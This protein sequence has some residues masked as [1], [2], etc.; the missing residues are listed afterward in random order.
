MTGTLGPHSETWRTV[1]SDSSVLIFASTPRKDG[2]GSVGRVPKCGRRVWQRRRGFLGDEAGSEHGE[3]TAWLLRSAA[4]REVAGRRA[5]RA[6]H[7]EHGQ[8]RPTAAA[9]LVPRQGWA[10]PRAAIQCSGPRRRGGLAFVAWPT[11]N[12]AGESVPAGP[13][14]GGGLCAG[15]ASTNGSGHLAYHGTA[16]VLRRRC[17]SA[18]CIGRRQTQG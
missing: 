14:Q 15:G 10:C 16:M 1:P 7:V 11:V 5:S 13:W 6:S 2:G 17:G 3:E 8:P 12:E 4:R 9:G 18:R